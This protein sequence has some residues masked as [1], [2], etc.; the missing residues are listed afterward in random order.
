MIKIF[1]NWNFTFYIEKPWKHK[2]ILTRFCTKLACFTLE[3]TH[4]RSSHSGKIEKKIKPKELPSCLILHLLVVF[5]WQLKILVTS[6]MCLIKSL[7]QPW[8]LHFQAII[9]FRFFPQ[10]NKLKGHIEL[11]GLETFCYMNMAVECK[12]VNIAMNIECIYLD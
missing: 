1:L 5:T 2:V 11:E 3:Q 10:A 6:L 8:G 7:G 9:S 4:E 12:I